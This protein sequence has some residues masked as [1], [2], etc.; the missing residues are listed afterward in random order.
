MR[1]HRTRRTVRWW[2]QGISGRVRWATVRDALALDHVVRSHASPLLRELAAAEMPLQHGKV[3][4]LRIAAGLVDG[5]VIRP[6]ESMSFNRLVGDATK[7]RG[8]V[9]GMRI[10]RGAPEAGVGGGLCQLANML[11]WL[12]LHSE[13]TVVERTEH[14]VD[15]FPDNERQVPWGSGC[16]IVYNYLDL[17]IRNDTTEDFQFFVTVDDSHLRGELRSSAAARTW[18]VEARDERFELEGSQVMRSNELWRISETSA[19]RV[20]ELIRRNRARVAYEV[21]PDQITV[22]RQFPEGPRL[23]ANGAL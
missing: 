11:H 19:G 17:V 9:D 23:E 18:R 8:F 6:G 5:V 21:A 1:A 4:N 16:T 10:A 12:A 7:K 20:E 2:L 22:K 15:L 3:T 13:L 14:D